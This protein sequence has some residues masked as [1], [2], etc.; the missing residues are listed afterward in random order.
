MGTKKKLIADLNRHILTTLLFFFGL[1]II[2][3]IYLLT[4][5][6][7]ENFIL[8]YQIEYDEKLVDKS[9]YNLFVKSKLPNYNVRSGIEYNILCSSLNDCENKRSILIQNVKDINK[10]LWIVAKEFLDV[11]IPEIEKKISESDLYFSN[12]QSDKTEDVDINLS[13]TYMMLLNL[14]YIRSKGEP[15]LIE[16]ATR[17]VDNKW[18]S[19]FNQLFNFTIL[20]VI[21]SLSLFFFLYILNP[22]R[23]KFRN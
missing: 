7:K 1:T 17:I 18:N 3:S 6:E 2:F 19:I 14:E 20:N 16:V 11:K 15:S 23:N 21:I 9:A 8:K 10:S 12:K 5:F 13:D 22:V 4:N